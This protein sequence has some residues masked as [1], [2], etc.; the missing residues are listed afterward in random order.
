MVTMQILHFE[1]LRAR[2]VGVLEVDGAWYRLDGHLE[3]GVE[4]FAAQETRETR[5]RARAAHSA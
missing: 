5:R 4:A 3:N 2:V 1:V